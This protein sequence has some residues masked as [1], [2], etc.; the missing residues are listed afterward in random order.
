MRSSASCRLQRERPTT[1]SADVQL[2]RASCRLAPI[3]R[4]VLDRTA[5]SGAVSVSERISAVVLRPY[6]DAVSSDLR[7]RFSRQSTLSATL[8]GLV[9][10]VV[11]GWALQAAALPSPWSWFVYVGTVL[12]VLVVGTLWLVP[13]SG[14]RHSRSE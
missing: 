12:V 8:L 6:R 3:R 2:K 7:R 11:A 5:P 1:S 13:R 4:A 10:F 9:A 14:G